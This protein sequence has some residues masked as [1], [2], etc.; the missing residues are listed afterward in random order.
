MY[1]LKEAIEIAG[2]L[3][4]KAKGLK[5]PAVSNWSRNKIISP[6]R[7]YRILEDSGARIGLYPDSLPIEIAVVAELKKDYKLNEIKAAR[8]KAQVHLEDSKKR[9]YEGA[10]EELNKGLAERVAALNKGNIDELKEMDFMIKAIQR[11]KLTMIYIKKY[12]RLKEKF[13]EGGA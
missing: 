9:D 3:T 13:N 6:L 11:T 10:I 4:G 12:N 8:E 1:E 5:P 7:G 2:K